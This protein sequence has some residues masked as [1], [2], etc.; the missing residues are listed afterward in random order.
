MAKK[1]KLKKE[2]IILIFIGAFLIVYT[3]AFNLGTY[4]DK[5][6]ET[7]V[8][9]AQEEEDTRSLMTQISVKNKIYISDSKVENIK[10]EKEYWEGMKFLFSEFSKIRTPESY[11][12]IYNGYSDDG[13]RFSTDLNYFRVYTVK[14]EEFYKIPIE[15]K[16]EVEK[17][18]RDSI[19]TSFDLIKQYKT[20]DNVE[21]A[22]GGQVKKVHK[23]KYDDLS[24]KMAS[25]RM[26]G[27]V[28]PEKS[29][30]RSKDNFTI[31]IQGEN[32]KVK[33]ETMGKDYVKITCGDTAAYYEVYTGL[34]EYLRDDIFK[35]E[36]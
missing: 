32:Y 36:Q 20:W 29:K 19:Y 18:L 6:N 26:V 16:K 1:R 13:I 2:V 21:L 4:L 5:N 34:Y 10:I 24:Y 17:I 9:Q 14:K 35:I 33:V 22:Y 28:Q 27:K 3:L 15:N 7:P 30:E 25:K 12:S 8:K 23:W 31:N 11:E